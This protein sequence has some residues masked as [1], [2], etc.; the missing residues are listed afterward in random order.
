MKRIYLL[1]VTIASVHHSY[2]QAAGPD[3]TISN[4]PSVKIGMPAIANN[5]Y[6]WTA[7]LPGLSPADPKSAETDVAPVQ[8]T[9]YALAV[10]GNEFSSLTKDT[11]TVF[12]FGIEYFRYTAGKEW[13]VVA[14]ES[15]EFSAIASA[16]C[17]DWDWVMEKGGTYEWELMGGKVQKGGL[18]ALTYTS[19][20]NKN[21]DF[22][23]THGT[24][25]V[26]CKDMFGD[27]HHL[28]STDAGIGKKAKVFFKK[29]DHTNPGGIDPNWFYYWQQFIPHNR[30]QI[31]VYDDTMEDYYGRTNV[32][33]R[34]TRIGRNASKFNQET[35]HNG[36]HT[37]YE[38][39]E[40]EN[41]H[42]VIWDTLWPDGYDSS[43]DLDRD[44]FPDVWE[45]TDFEALIYG[46][47][48]G[49]DDSYRIPE[50]AG[51]KYHED[52]CKAVERALEFD[53]YDDKDWSYDPTNTY[54]GKQ[55]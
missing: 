11:V 54:Q 39:M 28:L 50:S 37:F 12:R 13:K 26:S 38:I 46:F 19:M 47:V 52:K 25:E 20:P 40:H 43:K 21:D 24:L 30:I 16:D 22:G 29:D 44:R 10:T 1:L 14:G 51:F 23:E 7:V 32:R 42:L 9:S 2:S 18:M 36:L 27:N 53:K 48:V 17:S 5:C 8:T 4:R 33:L 49:N 55:W 31:L 3:R 34:R 6:H 41:H 45:Q 15:I 35:G